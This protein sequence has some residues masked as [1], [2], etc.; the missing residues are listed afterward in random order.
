MARSIRPTLPPG[1][2]DRFPV[3]L[4]QVRGI[5][6]MAEAGPGAGRYGTGSGLAVF[7]LKR[8]RTGRGPVG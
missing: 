4:R 7:G 6:A 5:N 2:T 8:A 3:R 1:A